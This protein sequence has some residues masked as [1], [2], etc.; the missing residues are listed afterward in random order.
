MMKVL[1]TVHE[2]FMKDTLLA[3]PYSDFNLLC[4]AQRSTNSTGKHIVFYLGVCCNVVSDTAD[5]FID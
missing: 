2:Q 4:F 3:E 5:I 1:N